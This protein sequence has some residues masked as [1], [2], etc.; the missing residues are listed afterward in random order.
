MPDSLPS[1]S[2][3][4]P[5]FRQNIAEILAWRATHEPQRV[6]FHFEQITDRNAPWENRYRSVT[7]REIHTRAI[8]IAALLSERYGDRI[9]S[10]RVVVAQPPGIEFVASF[11]AC[12][13]AEAIPVPV[14]PPSGR[15][16]SQRDERWQQ[17][18]SDALPLAVLTSEKFRSSIRESTPSET[19]II[20]TEQSNQRFN[21]KTQLPHNVSQSLAFLQYTSGS[22]G[23]PKGVAVTHANLT[24]N[25]E[26]IRRRFAHTSDSRGV[27]WLP[28]YHDM[29]LI[30]GILQPIFAGFPVLLISPTTFI[31]NPYRWLEAVSR[32]Q[33]TTSG[34]PN[35]AFEYAAQ[36]ISPE[37][38][39]KLDLAHWSVAFTG[40]ET[41]RSA[42]LQRF[43]STFES[44]GFQANAFLP[45]YGL[46]EATLMVSSGRGIKTSENSISCGSVIDG[47]ALQIVDPDSG[48]FCKHGEIGEIWVAGES[49][50]SGYWRRKQESR[51]TF[52]AQLST[53]EAGT[54][55]SFL[56]TGDLGKLQDGELFICGRIKDLIVV[57]GQNYFPT[58]LERVIEQSNAA[59]GIDSTAA[60]SVDDGDAETL[61]ILHE[62]DRSAVNLLGEE[63]AITAI[64]S[65]ISA[66]YALE[67]EEVVL[68]KPGSLPRTTSGKIRRQACKTVHQKNALNGV[69]CRSIL[70]RSTRKSDQTLSAPTQ[71]LLDPMSKDNLQSWLIDFLSQQLSVPRASISADRPL[72]ELGIDSV[73]AVQLVEELSNQ[74]KCD[75][76]LEAT[77]AWQYPT[78][79]AL[80]DYL[81]NP[82]LDPGDVTDSSFKQ[83]PIAIVGLAC[84]FPG[85]ANSPQAFWKLLREQVDAVTEIPADRW[86]SNAYFDND[87]ETAGKM[88]TRA[89]AF[90]DRIADFDPAFFGISPREA[91]YLDPQ[92]RLLL[93]SSYLA[94]EDAGFLP[95][96][97]NGSKT[98][99]FVGTGLDDYARRSFHSEDFKHVHQHSALGS[100]RGMAAGRIAYEFGLQGPSIQLDTTCS[101]SLVAVHLA[102][103]ALRNQEANLAIAGGVN[104]MLAPESTIACCKLRALSPDG[105]CFTF[106]ERANGYVRGEG[107][108]MI[109]VQRL[110]D[111]IAEGRPVYAV[112][113]GSAVN[114]DGVSNGLTAPNGNSQSAVI[115]A[116]LANADLTPE[117]MDYVE[118]HGTGTPLGDP[119]EINALQEVFGSRNTPLPI[120]SVKT[121]IGHLESAAGIA[122]LIKT[123]LA[124]QQGR[125][126]A[127]L[128]CQ[129][130]TSKIDWERSITK[131]SSQDAAWPN[132]DFRRA[133]INSFG[134][135]GTNVHVVLERLNDT[136]FRQPWD[137][138]EPSFG[139]EQSVPF[140]R[141]PYW[142][143]HPSEIEPT[144]AAP[145]VKSPFQLERIPLAGNSLHCFE[146]S[147]PVELWK[148]HKVQECVMLPAM[149][150]LWI[151]ATSFHQLQSDPWQIKDANFLTPLDLSDST[152][153]IQIQLA[154]NSSTGLQAELFSQ[155]QAAWKQHTVG[156][157]DV[158]ST[159]QDRCSKTPQP[160]KH[161]RR[162]EA[163]EFYQ[164]YEHRGIA[165]GPT[166]Q[167][168]KYVDVDQG[169]V[170]GHLNTAQ[171]APLFVPR[172][173]D[174]GLQ[175]AG[176]LLEQVAAGTNETF[177]PSAIETFSANLSVLPASSD[178]MI[179][180]ARRENDRINISWI[181]PDQN[182]VAEL[183]GLHV[184]P[185]SR[186]SQP[187]SSQEN[188]ARNDQPSLHESALHHQEA[189]PYYEIDWVHQQL[190]QATTELLKRPT[191][192]ENANRS[193]TRLLE[194]SDDFMR[195]QKEATFLNRLAIG[196]MQ[197]AL[198][199]VPKPERSANHQQLTARFFKQIQMQED[200]TTDQPES[201]TRK[202]FI[203][204]QFVEQIGENLPAI[205]RGELDPLQILFPNGD[206]SSLTKLYQSS[207]SGNILNSTLR[208]AIRTAFKAKPERPL[209]II[210]VGAGTGGTT[211]HVLE[212]LHELGIKTEYYFTDVSRLFLSQSQT[213]FADAAHIRFE[214]LNIEQPIRDQGFSAD[215]D[216]A[217]A[218][219]VLHATV[220]LVKSLENL[221]TLIAPGGLALIL[222]ATEPHAWLDLVFGI[223]EGWWRF[224]DHDLRPDHPLLSTEQWKFAC[225][226]AGFAD[227]EVMSNC[228]IMAEKEVTSAELKVEAS[229]QPTDSLTLDYSVDDSKV[230]VMIPPVKSVAL[231]TVKSEWFCGELIDAFRNWID[232]HG[233]Q[234]KRFYVVCSNATAEDRLATA[235]IWGLMQTLA[236]EHPEVNATLISSDCDESTRREIAANSPESRVKIENNMRHVPRLQSVESARTADHRG[237][238]GPSP[239]H[240]IQ[241][242]DTT[243]AAQSSRKL[244]IDNPGEL[245][246]LSWQP[247]TRRPPA[248]NEV[249]LRVCAAGINFR[250]VLIAMGIYP[251]DAELGCECVGIAVAVGSDVN[252]VKIGDRIAT[253]APG[254]LGS[255]VTVCRSLIVPV[256]SAIDSEAAATLPVAFATALYALDSLAQLQ[257]GETVLWHS[258]TGGVGQAAI[259]VANS[260]GATVY[261][262][263]SETKWPALTQLGI[264]RPLNSRTTEF[265]QI[266]REETNGRGVDVVVNCLPWEFREASLDA[267]AEHGRFVEIGKG[268]GL[269]S[270]Q[271]RKLR[272]DISHHTFDLSQLCQ[273]NPL[274][275]DRLL[276]RAFNQVAAGKW[277]PPTWSTY[278]FNEATNAFRTMQQAKHIGKLVLKSDFTT[279]DAGKQ[280]SSVLITGGLGGLGL[281]TAQCLVD[282]G[283]RHLLLLGRNGITTRFQQD[284][285]NRMR[286]RGATVEIIKADVADKN[287]LASALQPY[288][289]EASSQPL[290]G[291][292]HAAGVLADGALSEQNRKTFSAVFAPKA[293]GA[294]NLHQLTQHSNLDYFILFSSAT[295]LFGSPGQANHAAGN[296]YLN[297]LVRYRHSIGLPALSLAWGPWSD[298]GS[299]VGYTRD[300]TLR[301]IPGIQLISPS[302][303]QNHLETLIHLQHRVIAVLPID[304]QAFDSARWSQALGLH[305]NVHESN[306]LKSGKTNLIKRSSS[307]SQG[308]KSPIVVSESGTLETIVCR[309]VGRAL[310]IS[311]DQLDRTKGLF[312]MGLDS[313][314]ALELKNG[315][316]RDL[317]MD[318][319]VSIAFDYPTVDALIS[320]LTERTVDCQPVED[321]AMKPI[322]M[323]TESTKIAQQLDR[324][325]SEIDELFKT[326]PPK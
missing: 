90:I 21:N 69:R 104:L 199:L 292:I 134:I 118:A 238:D 14:P 32:F 112:I 166:F 203:E 53:T 221:Q 311:G 178:G 78:I 1:Q 290:G 36:K 226:K 114:H 168:L 15:S 277:S 138:T 224:D 38:R 47:L 113:R 177:V 100:M 8:S 48:S 262:T 82:S 124:M 94:L 260:M 35:F 172:L 91:L 70:N 257:P 307:E 245:D 59:L 133:G 301:G 247:L 230:L 99:V 223:T 266:L 179:I 143:P 79:N 127:H 84:R 210:E 97:L 128:N 45:C 234:E 13:Y 46:A 297:G 282:R 213:K 147:L 312:D 135:S 191:R 187:H 310:G 159:N 109:V 264:K 61:V 154:C 252:D 95:F 315:L 141:Q 176:T 39:A 17:V 120:G 204:Q 106:S 101:S 324:K 294:W 81:A 153:Q 132:I 40:A 16:N 214:L 308:T 77:L 156:H 281:A 173:W 188:V 229:A 167:L 267:L 197:E 62:L 198:R 145:A 54:Q 139:S 218:A 89:G 220:D 87:P 215:F 3:R 4:D 98:G 116:A 322:E 244:V 274:A 254:C 50:A 5:I 76:P 276:K 6:G 129:Q 33:A 194:Q 256:P 34:G 217:I 52:Q 64:R 265:A 171:Q 196:Y 326:N 271:M 71:L 121:N 237:K 243:I 325:L 24:H 183:T 306:S 140:N 93:E 284:A 253:I 18:Q 211:G 317:Q 11:F 157:I 23:T 7:Y 222:E 300:G 164:R 86:N 201:A 83:D 216:L 272:P 207:S 117:T 250:D 75:R 285:V 298:I 96:D 184:S 289:N 28:P 137:E 49:V 126:P 209:R 151:L 80:C 63:A 235:A 158:L 241:T 269:S 270:A 20:A 258:A 60:F 111:A 105:K 12:L 26:Q 85:G 103:Q 268:D 175:V 228:V 144:S 130:K 246:Q 160:T 92:Q 122:S 212:E 208:R 125:I 149:A 239:I 2:D 110:S 185:I 108:G 293:M 316:Q 57:R 123:V 88:Y 263:A 288:L 58:D 320:F 10:A 186:I 278:R 313:L 180:W 309:H 295:G 261:A 169:S 219:N 174:A 190:P 233:V 319:P 192:I 44:C 161:A 286:E 287:A 249:E 152:T 119:I 304:W 30:G 68:L 200:L 275:I 25:L 240:P 163:T 136:S 242:I 150:Q 273:Q 259:Q 131:V 67:I 102:C 65:S 305:W 279:S 283:N 27:I 291:V 182:I 73:R 66:N 148:E 74:L 146:G 37:K 19:V 41:I 165:Y 205:L 55:Q 42:T 231:A 162:V 299:A 193:D 303:G 181:T 296:S 31:R 107:C 142:L 206:T 251:E 202:D 170:I 155:E 232:D 318:L 56:R 189:N 227:V 302:Q 22:T 9:K 323:P 255:F 321:R 29:G 280:D 51:L 248:S 195:Y 72:A 314:T 115:R 225:T 236:L 43:A